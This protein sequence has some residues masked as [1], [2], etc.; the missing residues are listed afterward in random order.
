MYP[1]TGSVRT[2]R[3][4]T[5]TIYASSSLNLYS[6]NRTPY[7]G[8]DFFFLSTEKLNT[9]TVIHLVA[10]SSNRPI[11]CIGSRPFE[12]SGLCYINADAFCLLIMPIAA[13]RY[14]LNGRSVADHRAC[15]RSE[16]VL[17]KVPNELGMSWRFTRKLIRRVIGGY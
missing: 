10:A 14:G 16:I 13:E 17:N 4:G 9:H 8:F 5:V 12:T 11:K 3:P 2:A 7:P 15:A 1:L 6:A